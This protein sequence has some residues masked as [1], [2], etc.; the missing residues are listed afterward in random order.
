MSFL[1]NLKGKVSKP[2][3][4]AGL[5]KSK[6]FESDE[7]KNES[8]KA[9]DSFDTKKGA[10]AGEVALGHKAKLVIKPINQST[11]LRRKSSKIQNAPDGELDEATRS[12]LSGEQIEEIGSRVIPVKDDSDDDN[13][14]EAGAENTAQDYEDVP[15]EEFGAALLRG[16]GWKGPDKTSTSMHT[17]HRQRGALLGIGAKPVGKELELELLDR[18]N[19]S[20]PLIKKD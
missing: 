17:R 6:A 3:K 20:V 14:G 11:K 13:F 9:I 4:K 12:L 5:N 18:K 7:P 15:V 1:F 8:I 19:L 16:M 10:M 2:V